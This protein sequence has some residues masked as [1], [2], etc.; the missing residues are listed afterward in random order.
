MML[1]SFKMIYGGVYDKCLCLDM[2]LDRVT[3]SLIDEGESLQW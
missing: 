2:S 3:I 1:G